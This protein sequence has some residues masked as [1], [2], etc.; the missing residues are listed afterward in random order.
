MDAWMDFPA[1]SLISFNIDRNL[2]PVYP[3]PSNPVDT[4]P[5]ALAGTWCAPGI[6]EGGGAGSVAPGHDPESG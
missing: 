1:K 2:R 4:C 3:R 6:R 5:I